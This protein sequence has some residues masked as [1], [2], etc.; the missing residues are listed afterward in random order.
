MDQIQKPIQYLTVE[1]TFITGSIENVDWA[2]IQNWSWMQIQYV[3]KL[4]VNKLF[5]AETLLNSNDYK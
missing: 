5:E 1:D 3:K 2:L 4:F